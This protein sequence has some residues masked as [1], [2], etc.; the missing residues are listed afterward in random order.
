M[1][2]A[3]ELG[4]RYTCLDELAPLQDESVEHVSQHLRELAHTTIENEASIQEEPAQ[5]EE[6]V[7]S[8]APAQG[9]EQ[10]A[11]DLTNLSNTESDRS[12]DMVT[13]KTMNIDRFVPGVR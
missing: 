3:W 5:P 9:T 8:E 12:R 1:G 13:W 4:R 2:E 11:V 6:L 10:V 7:E